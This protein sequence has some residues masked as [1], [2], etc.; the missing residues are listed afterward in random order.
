MDTIT[1][2]SLVVSVV[3]LFVGVS[4]ARVPQED[5]DPPSSAS[6]STDGNGP[7]TVQS[8]ESSGPAPES[9]TPNDASAA[10]GTDSYRQA[11]AAL[12]AGYIVCTEIDLNSGDVRD[13]RSFLDRRSRY[14]IYETNLSREVR[15]LGIPIPEKRHWVIIYRP[16]SG[17]MEIYYAYEDLPRKARRLLRLLDEV[18]ASDK[19]RR[20]ILER[21]MT[22]LRT[23]RSVSIHK[24]DMLMREVRDRYGLDGPSL[25]DFGDRLRLLSSEQ[26]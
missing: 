6:R 21:L 22:S 4:C 7:P 24:A 12:A 15:R 25:P 3:V 20:A 9:P 13:T 14:E 23:E 1:K 17:G 16:P 2:L 5:Q 8:A 11:V 10:V 18:N 19:E 26:E